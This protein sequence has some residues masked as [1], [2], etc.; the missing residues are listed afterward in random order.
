MLL[1]YNVVIF[2][3]KWQNVDP[4]SLD[5]CN[6]AGNE[7]YRPDTK[8]LDIRHHRLEWGVFGFDKTKREESLV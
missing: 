5:I 7:M 6:I 3:K 2:A 4:V 1:Y 8:R